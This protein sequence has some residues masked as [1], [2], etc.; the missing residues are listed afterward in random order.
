VEIEARSIGA[1]LRVPATMA[2]KPIP[3]VVPWYGIEP[4]ESFP[5]DGSALVMW[6][7]GNPP[8]PVTNTPPVYVA[9]DPEWAGLL[10]CPL[11]YEGDPH[12]CPRRQPEARLQKSEFLKT[13]GAVIDT[14]SGIPCLAP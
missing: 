10:A 11:R 6:D 1:K 14:C 5:Y 8:A 13:N 2:G 3:D 7:S 4:I 12:E 9:G